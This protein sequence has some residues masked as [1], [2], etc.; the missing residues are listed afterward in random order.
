MALGSGG[1]G[2]TDDMGV[3]DFRRVDEVG[4]VRRRAA[5]LADGVV[6]RVG[7]TL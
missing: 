1:A 5:G 4:I 3:R 2:N 6:G 7:G